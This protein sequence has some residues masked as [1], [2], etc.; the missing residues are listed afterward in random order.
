MVFASVRASLPELKPWMV[1]AVDDYSQEGA[2]VWCRQAAG[3]FMLRQEF[4]YLLLLAETEEHVGTAGIF[5]VDWKAGTCEIGYWQTTRHSGHGYMME[6]V[7]ALTGLAFGALSMG[8]VEI[9]TDERNE[10]SRRVAERCGYA[11]EGIYRRVKLDTA[12]KHY[13]GCVYS[14]LRA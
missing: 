5:T 8:R 3:K 10:R 4:H 1:W 12:G 13:D 9:G 7:E 11:L 2:E 14:K 6:A